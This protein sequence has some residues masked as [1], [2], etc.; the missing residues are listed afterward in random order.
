MDHVCFM[1]FGKSLENCSDYE[2]QTAFDDL[3]TEPIKSTVKL[4]EKDDTNEN[5][6]FIKYP[7]LS[8]YRT[9]DVP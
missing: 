8:R 4:L 5:T 7:I 3:I 9:V 2:I 1:E 6:D